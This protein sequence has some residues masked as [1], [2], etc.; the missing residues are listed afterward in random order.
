MDSEPSF[1]ESSHL[2]H[3]ESNQL[4]DIID[5]TSKSEKLTVS[6]IVQSYYQVMKISS[7][8]KI[9][10]DN[11]QQNQPKN[12]QIQMNEKVVVYYTIYY[13]FAVCSCKVFV[14]FDIENPG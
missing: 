9:L 11:F 13:I 4:K 1:D 7:I 10:E 3:S 5:L 14:S 12:I 6:E 8:S 2:F